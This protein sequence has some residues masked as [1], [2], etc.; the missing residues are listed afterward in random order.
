MAL[1]SFILPLLIKKTEAKMHHTIFKSIG[2]YYCFNCMEINDRI[3][4]EA[5]KFCSEMIKSGIDPNTGIVIN[6]E[7]E[8]RY[9]SLREVVN[10]TL[11]IKSGQTCE[12]VLEF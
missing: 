8:I 7:T 11:K 2:S 5:E 6:A 3:M 10:G 1:I 12:Y 9:Y 4:T